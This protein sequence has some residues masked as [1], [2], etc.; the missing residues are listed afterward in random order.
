MGWR[1]VKSLRR[2]SVVLLVIVLLILAGVIAF[3]RPLRGAVERS[4]ADQLAVGLDTSNTPRVSLGGW[5]FAW[6]AVTQ[7]FPSAQ[8]EIDQLT[9]D[10]E[11]GPLTLQ[12]VDLDLGNVRVVDGGVHSD[13]VNGT[14]L[15]PWRSVESFSGVPI[16]DGGS[17]RLR[18]EVFTSILGFQVS[19]VLSGV[20]VLDE[21]SQTI[22]VEQPEVEISGVVVPGS[23][24]EWVIDEFVPRVP[25]D[26]PY[27]L[28]ATSVEAREHGLAVGLTGSDVTMTEEG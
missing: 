27:G 22:T 26:L 3:D 19:G 17:G 18:V 7:S 16:G 10:T 12:H 28:K 4:V 2:V 25:I 15:V 5:P 9:V 8:V 11:L 1:A 23:V 20:P 24:T 13:T 14:V 6:Y 21:A